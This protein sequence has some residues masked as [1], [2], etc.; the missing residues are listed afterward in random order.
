MKNKKTIGFMT[1]SIGTPVGFA[2]WQGVKKAARKHNVKLIT[3]DGDNVGRKRTLIYELL[4]KKNVDGVLTWAS[5]TSDEYTKFYSERMG[6]LPIVTLTLPIDP[7]PVV[8]I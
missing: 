8:Q 5:N 4:K 1:R 3:I 6:N 7:Y 2:I